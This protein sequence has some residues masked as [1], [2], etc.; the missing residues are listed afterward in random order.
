MRPF[1]VVR[2]VCDL[3]FKFPPFGNNLWLLRN[4]KVVFILVIKAANNRATIVL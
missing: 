2:K 4:T 3:T 1:Y